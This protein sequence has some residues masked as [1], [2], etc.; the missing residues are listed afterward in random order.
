M[1]TYAEAQKWLKKIGGK[2]LQAKEQQRGKGSVTVIVESAK[3]GTVQRHWLFDDTLEGY[4]REIE[5]RRA[6]VRACEELQ[7]ALD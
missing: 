3:R 1:V 6:F 7:R 4:E 2:T 5:I